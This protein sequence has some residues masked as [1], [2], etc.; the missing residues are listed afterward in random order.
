MTEKVF[1]D[2]GSLLDE[3]GIDVIC[4]HS[5]T[6]PGG[7]WDAYELFVEG[8]DSGRLVKLAADSDSYTVNLILSPARARSSRESRPA[9]PHQAPWPGWS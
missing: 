6:G 5:Y 3:S 1:D 4:K 9:P 7:E 2:C 8:H